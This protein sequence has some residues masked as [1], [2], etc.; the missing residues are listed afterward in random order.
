MN[1]G[2]QLINTRVLRSETDCFGDIKSFSKKVKYFIM[3]QPFKY[4]T[5]NG[6]SETGW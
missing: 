2:E 6:K 3:K 1:D 4:L 5:T